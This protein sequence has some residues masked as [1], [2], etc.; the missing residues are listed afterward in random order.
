ML[1]ANVLV[2][3][4]YFY[5]MVRIAADVSVDV[6]AIGVAVFASHM[7]VTVIALIIIA[8]VSHIVIALHS[9]KA[10]GEVDDTEDERDTLIKLRGENKSGAILGLGVVIVIGMIL[11]GNGPFLTANMLLFSLVVSETVAGV[12]KLLDYRRSF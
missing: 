10:D 11:V 2:Y 9:L 4:W 5:N 12:F 1:T 8:I 3:G 7:I 6:M